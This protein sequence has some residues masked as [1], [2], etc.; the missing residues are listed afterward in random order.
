LVLTEPARRSAVTGGSGRSRPE[1]LNS[2]RPV[3][4]DRLRPSSVDERDSEH[5]GNI[6]IKP[7]LHL[8]VTIATACAAGK[9]QRLKAASDGH[10]LPSTVDVVGPIKAVIRLQM[11]VHE[12][13][14]R[15]FRVRFEEAFNLYCQWLRNGANY[16]GSHGVDATS[17]EL[18]TLRQQP[19]HR[20]IWSG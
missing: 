7:P 6:P 14:I 19:Q 1:P 9:H 8:V 15:V 4:A 13:I 17:L 5:P 18:G 2:A 10:E 20:I 11:K 3:T 16:F 12:R